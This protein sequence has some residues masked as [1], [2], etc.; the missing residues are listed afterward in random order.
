MKNKTSRRL[1]S[2]ILSLSMLLGLLPFGPIKSD[3]RAAELSSDILNDLDLSIRQNNIVIEA[4]GTINSD[5][6]LRVELSMSIPVEGDDPTPEQ[7]VRKGDVLTIPLSDAFHL[8]NAETIAL[9]MGSIIVGHASFETDAESGM[10]SARVV[11]DGDDE[12]FDGTYNDVRLNFAADMEYDKSGENGSAGN[13]VVSILEKDFIVNVPELPIIY[14]MNKAGSVDLADQSI[15]WTVNVSATQGGQPYSLEGYGFKDD[16]SA[17]GSYIEGSFKLNGSATTPVWSNNNLSYTFGAGSAGTATISF[18]TKIPDA[19]YYSSSSQAVDNKALLLDEDEI[20]VAKGETSVQFTPEWIEKSGVSSDQSSSGVYDP[21]NRTITW[22]IIAN[23]MSASLRNVVVTDLLTGGLEFSSASV[24][25]W[26]SNEWGTEV[27]VTPNASGE[28]FLGDINRMFLLTIVS[29]VPDEDYTTGQKTFNNTASIRWDG[30]TGGGTGIGSGSVG[31]VIGYNAMSKTGV[32]DK[33]NQKIRWTVSIDPKGQNIPNMKVYDL[34]VYGKSINL[35]TVSGIPAGINPADLTARY[36]QKYAGNFSGAYTAN[37]IP[38]Y[39]GGL[40]VADLIEVTGLDPVD[41]STFSF[42]STVLDPDVF[43]GNSNIN[44]QNTATLFS[45]YTKVNSATGTVS[46]QSRMLSKNMLKR[47]AMSDPAAGINSQLTSNLSEG[48]DYIDKSVIFRL[49]VNANGLNFAGAV[50][51]NGELMGDATLVDTLP[52]GWEFVPIADGIDFYIFD[53]KG[54][55]NG[56]V[57][58]VDTTPDSVDGLT[59]A[60]S[61]RTAEFTFTNLNKPYVILVKAR[62][63]DDTVASYFDSNESNTVRNTSKLTGEKWSTGVTSTQDVT[64]NSRILDKTMAKPQDGE[65]LWTLDYKPYNLGLSGQ[66][67]DDVLPL[68]LDIRTDASGRLV[69]EGNI[70]AHELILNADGSYTK[71]AA[72][73]LE[74]G[75]TVKYDPETRVLS[76]L[77]PDHMKGY[78]FTYYTDITGNPGQV[79]NK[80]SLMGEDG[81]I[82]D[83]S[84][85]YQITAADGS[86]SLRRNGSIS[87][88]KINGSGNRLAGAEFTLFAEDG[89]TIVKRGVTDSQGTLVLKV[90]PDGRY[91]LRETAVPAGYNLDTTVHEVVVST[92]GGQVTTSV[93]GKTGTNANALTVQNFLTGTVGKLEINKTVAGDGADANKRFNFTLLLTG[94]TGVYNYIGNGVANGT[95]RSGDRFSLAHGESITIVGLPKDASYVV[96]ED[97]YAADGYQS[98]STGENGT[99]VADETKTASFTNT[100]TVGS[101]SIG[102][103][104]SGQFGELTRKFDFT[105]VFQGAPGVYPYS[106]SA[107]GTIRSGDTISLAHGESITITDLP[108]GATYTVTEADYS[109]DHYETSYLGATGTII[110][111]ETVEAQFNNLSTR[112]S[113]TISKEVSGEGADPEKL[114]D[115]TIE[116]TGAA[117]S[118]PYSG[119]YTG[120]IASGDTISLAHGE[121]ITISGLPAGTTYTVTEADYSADEYWSESEGAQGVIETDLTREAVFVN[122]KMTGELSISKEVDGEGADPDKLWDFTITFD[123]ANESYPYSGSYTGTIQSGDTISLAHGES[124]TITGLPAGATYT[125]TEADYTA[126]EY[127]SESEGAEGVIVGEAEQ[128][129]AFVNTKMTGELSISKEVDGEG[130]D[131]DKLWDFTI[132]FD[133]ANESYPYS[134]SYT[135]TI[136]S[137]DTISL[138]HGESITITDLPAGATYT[139]TE[140]DYTADEYRSESEGA[141]GVIVGEA[142]QIAAFVNT[143]MS[144]ELTISKLLAGEGG[145]PDKKFDF[146]VSFDGANESYPYSGSY[147]GTIASGDTISLA[148]G[149]NITITG[150]PAGATYTV[151]EADYTAEEYKSSET[152]LEGV[153]VGEAKAVAGFIN[154]KLTGQLTLTKEVE[155]EGADT[156]KQFEFTITLA[157]LVE[158][159]PYSGSKSGLIR[160][161]DKISLAHGESI[162]ITGLPAGVTYKVTEADYTADEYRSSGQGTSGVIVGERE[163]VASFVNS[164]MTGVLTI[165]KMVSGE[166]ADRSKKF[167]FKVVFAGAIGSYTYSGSQNGTIRSGDTVSLAHGESITIKGLPA[168]ASY[169]VTEADYTSANYVTTSEGASGV[170]K[171]EAEKKASFTNSWMTGELSIKKT[172]SGKGSNTNKSFDF[173]V[174]FE[175]ASG[176]YPYSGSKSGTIR[177]GGKIS[178]KHGESITI[179]GLPANAGYKVTEA[180]YT[181]DHY[182]VRATGAEGKIVAKK[183]KTASFV[184]TY[185][186]PETDTEFPRTGRPDGFAQTLAGAFSLAAGI[187]LLLATRYKKRRR[188]QEE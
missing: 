107:E 87:I 140:A 128:I 60:I 13:H 185:K 20:E 39:Q 135:G 68:G 8:I 125:V 28:Y 64:I 90:I 27:S 183:T 52:A 43:A 173:I 9:K 95:I 112:G 78:R 118:Y 67:L 44:V 36:S 155:G 24:Q 71:G 30:Y 179:T 186:I 45:A 177:S 100:R 187:P 85:P 66:Y 147:T 156:S 12:V 97:N 37:V 5:L 51:A 181:K 120:T 74:P 32:A 29:R 61:G 119:S 48:F 160:S 23:H 130:A 55:S 82:E 6:P 149:E 57:T 21:K 132:T 92:A 116:F 105:I 124:V 16:L 34:L 31:V 152:T 25:Y 188:E 150:L 49:S 123:G 143:K 88:T 117:G 154:S 38:V 108:A 166:G 136:Q 169:T 159:Y 41:K 56:R 76:F 171:G 70:T 161:G 114:W 17:V 79:S 175:G 14:N 121:S 110:K 138:A 91:I 98:S 146:T 3:V 184:N 65:L 180:D 122:T 134:G 89:V 7:P 142:K 115:F 137:G 106:G 113:L 47:G 93:D 94:A 84:K 33:A 127:W 151:T 162:T 62:P 53:G 131:P 164:K 42:D 109:S 4:G 26:N 1:F 22:T 102:K 139:V 168:G 54:E 170:I 63:T 101:L 182:T 172:V 129:A 96:T 158:A 126:D 153:I 174:T 178:L 111:D 81:S 58:A 15:T 167:D 46:F 104:V 40:R 141:Q 35:N 144:G 163:K 99:I 10:V 83:V 69:I 165:S 80:V 103:Q 72:I 18:K 176:S 50:N 133:G 86:A 145:D 59:A 2:L 19:K 148:H 75:D 11:F 73:E 77:I 157:G